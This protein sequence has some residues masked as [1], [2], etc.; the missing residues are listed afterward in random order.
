MLS[1]PVT[2]L[3]GGP[4]TP[5]ATSSARSA[6]RPLLTQD[7]V[8][9]HHFTVDVEECFHVTALSRH[10][11]RSQWDG[12][13]SRVAVGVGRL[14][15]TLALHQARATFFVLGWVAARH[16]ELIRAIAGAGHEVASHGWGHELVTD[17]TPEEFRVSV[18]R[19]KRALE[20]LTGAPVLGF[21]A[22]SFSIVPGREWALDVLIEEGYRY[23]SSLVPARRLNGGYPNGGRAPHWITR[24]SGRLAEI[25]PATVRRFGVTF[26]AG[27]GAYFR[28]FPYALVRAALREHAGRG[29]PATFYIHPWELD[30]DQPRIA[31]PFATRLRTYGGLGRVA[32]RLQ[33]LFGEFQFG[34]IA[35][36]VAAMSVAA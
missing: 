20:D 6:A 4:A 2:V 17:Q 12:L 15:E 21:R 31:A 29:E 1:R 24:P 9:R 18:R 10:V 30:L 28:L 23:D 13:P 8:I 5:R 14:L 26:P 7:S 34:P 11:A 16:G 25:P 35:A 33:R 19:S 27:G 3:R 22:P 36:T 32:G